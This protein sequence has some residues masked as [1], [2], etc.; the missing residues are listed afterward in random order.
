MI[1]RRIIN[2]TQF[3]NW[4]AVCSLIFYAIFLNGGNNWVL[5][6]E[7]GLIIQLILLSV[8]W[9]LGVKTNA[10]WAAYDLVIILIITF[11]ELD[12]RN[13][14]ETR[15]FHGEGGFAMAYLFIFVVNLSFL[16]SIRQIRAEYKIVRG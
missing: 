4:L 1:I 12:G 3:I 14:I 6:L 2:I 9:R 8:N 13:I 11:L 7:I 16:L 5:A 15:L 10:K